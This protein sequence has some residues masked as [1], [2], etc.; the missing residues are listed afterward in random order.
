MNRQI[1]ITYC[2]HSTTPH[3]F[4]GEEMQTFPQQYAT[5]QAAN[6]CK[7]HAK[8]MHPPSYQLSTSDFPAFISRSKA[9][10]LLRSSLRS[11][12]SSQLS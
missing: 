7:S 11:L 1:E 4:I 8:Y 5:S 6:A 3:G 12:S 10:F 9:H 2:V